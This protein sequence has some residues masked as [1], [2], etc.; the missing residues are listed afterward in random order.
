MKKITSLVLIM[1]MVGLL[2]TG[3]GTT[4]KAT[5]DDD[6]SGTATPAISAKV[7]SLLVTLN[8]N[9]APDNHEWIT[10][11][12]SD[13]AV[14]GATVAVYSGW[15][16]SDNLLL[17]SSLVYGNGTFQIDIGDKDLSNTGVYLV[18]TEPG[19]R[20]SEPVIITK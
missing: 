5:D 9:V 4:K 6:D 11:I 18:Q 10:S 8:E 2:F 12:D 7:E 16:Y 15:P 1:L 20:T 13:A 14:A 17:G 3:C 19:K